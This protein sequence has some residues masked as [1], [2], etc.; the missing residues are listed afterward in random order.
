MK[1]STTTATRQRQP[2]SAAAAA[3]SFP[4]NAC[5][6]YRLGHLPDAQDVERLR[7]L[8][9][10][11]VESFNYFLRHGLHAG[12][13]EMERTEIDLRDPKLSENSNTHDDDVTTV[14]FWIENVQIRKPCKAGNVRLYPRECRERGIM[15]SGE[16][17]GTFAYRF[18]E[19]RNRLVIP[20]RI[21]KVQKTFGDMP[22][23]VLSDACH[24]QDMTPRQLVALREE[25]R[26]FPSH[27]QTRNRISLG[28][29][30]L[31]R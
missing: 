7:R 4:R 6:S 15:Y 29:F 5:P 8:T 27:H 24:L 14:Q 28:T 30:H 16:I 1:N 18:L 3:A 13:R 17:V 25:V 10:P 9:A 21:Q 26:I 23:M 22:I 31:N 20:G 19:R 2:S 12:I 11:H